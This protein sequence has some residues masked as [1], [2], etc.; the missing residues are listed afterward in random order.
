M[1][2]QPVQDETRMRLRYAGACRVCGIE[3]PA[4]AEAIY[5]RATKTVRC[6]THDV[7]VEVDIAPEPIVDTVVD[8]GTPGASAR[9]EFDRRRASRERQ[10]R[11]KHPKI[12]GLIHALSDEP[13][14]TAAWDKGAVGEERLG[15]RLN[16]LSSDRLRVLH[17]GRLPGS[18]APRLPRQYLPPHGHTPTGIYV[19]DAKKYAGRPHLMAE[20]GLIRP[21]MET[22]LV[23]G[24]NRTKL[25]DGVRKQAEVVSKV[26]SG[27]IPVHP[28]LC[29]L[30]P[31]GRSSAVPSTRA[32]SIC[33]GPRS[34]TG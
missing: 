32:A 16:A 21:R 15:N 2:E 17:D 30:T 5:E 19:I 24:R 12:G 27:D 10:I 29:L 33:C 7:E 14:S 11:K 20:G 25:V 6:A 1:T 23:G 18:P 26:I 4:K 28:V 34:S 13:Q 9:R 31:T 22:L 8:P 3:I